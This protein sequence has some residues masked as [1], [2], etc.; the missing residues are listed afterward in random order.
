M[1]PVRFIPAVLWTAVVLKLLLSE[2]DVLPFWWLQFPNADKLI[3]VGLFGVNTAL[4]LY[5]A[6]TVDLQKYRSRIVAFIALWTLA[7]GAVTELAQHLLLV[8]RS[9]DILD[10]L[11]DVMGGITPLAWFLLKVQKAD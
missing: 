7:L 8:T 2:S 5:A 3:H 4:L 1:W 11:A 9:G 6:N 10:L